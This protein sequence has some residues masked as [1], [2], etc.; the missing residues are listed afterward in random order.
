MCLF[1]FKIL[2]S[3]KAIYRLIKNKTIILGG[4]NNGSFNNVLRAF[5]ALLFIYRIE[6]IEVRKVL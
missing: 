6:K 2:I 3:P 1:Y 4:H 5:L